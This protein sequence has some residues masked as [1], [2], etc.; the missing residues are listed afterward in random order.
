[1]PSRIVRFSNWLESPQNWAGNQPTSRVATRLQHWAQFL[2]PSWARISASKHYLQLS[3]FLG[4]SCLSQDPSD[5]QSAQTKPTIVQQATDAI[6]GQTTVETQA[7]GLQDI[8]QIFE[9]RSKGGFGKNPIWRK[10]SASCANVHQNR[11]FAPPLQ[12]CQWFIPTKICRH[13]SLP[14]PFLPEK[15]CVAR[16]CWKCENPPLW[17]PIMH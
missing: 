11:R 9:Q 10:V 16:S 6:I 14:E 7:K 3:L 2:A 12:G 15:N 4:C 17:W 5:P 13:K 8:C 1:M